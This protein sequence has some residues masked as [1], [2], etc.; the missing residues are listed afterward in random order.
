MIRLCK[1]P[2]FKV[3]INKIW[4]TKCIVSLVLYCVWFL[5]QLYYRSNNI[6]FLIHLFY[7]KSFEREKFLNTTFSSSQIKTQSIKIASENINYDA[8]IDTIGEGGFCIVYR[9]LYENKQYVAVK[10][11]KTDTTHIS[12]LYEDYI[13]R[14]ARCIR[15]LLHP[16][17]ATFLGIIWKPSFHAIVLEYYKNGNLLRFM[18]DNYLHPFLKAKLLW[19]VSKGADYLHWLPKQIIHNDIK[20]ENILISD[21]ITAKLT[22]FGMAHWNSYTSDVLY[23]QRH[24]ELP[25]GGTATHKSPERWL[26][27]NERSTKC[28][29]YSYGILIWE[30]YCESIPFISCTN[31]EIKLAVTDGQRPDESLLAKTNISPFMADVMRHCWKQLPCERPEMKEVVDKLET[32]L[33]AD[34]KVKTIIRNSIAKI[35][36]LSADNTE[37]ANKKLSAESNSFNKDLDNNE[38]NTVDEALVSSHEN[39]SAYT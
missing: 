4:F 15:N 21:E 33:T 26:D 12:E 13:K 9:A 25:Q 30:T 20:I 23:S 19:D 22:D 34:E 27:I 35:V 18:R 38:T 39:Y 10:R 1:K 24:V 14:E 32:L 16:N 6:I 17:I 31:E 3:E 11:L 8:T 5:L 36:T 37:I 28:D 2:L 29:V 7:R